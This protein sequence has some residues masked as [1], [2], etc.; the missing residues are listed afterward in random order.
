MIQL[1]TFLVVAALIC[2]ASVPLIASDEASAE[3]VDRVRGLLAELFQI[4]LD[5]IGPDTTLAALDLDELDLV[6]AVMEVE[7][8]FEVSIPEDDLAAAAGSD[9]A[10]VLLSWLTPR[11]LALL[12]ERA[13]EHD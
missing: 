5:A 1:R 13:L 10:D 8:S 11:R 4:E 3:A 9:N 6:E 12:A 7:D 2:A